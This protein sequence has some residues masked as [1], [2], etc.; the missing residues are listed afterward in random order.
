MPIH[1]ISSDLHKGNINRYVV[2]LA[3]TMS[4]FRSLGLSL[5]DVIKAVTVAPANAL[6][7]RQ[8]G[9][10]TLEPG[11]PANISIF[12]ETEQPVEMEDAEGIVRVSSKWIQPRWCLINGTC[13]ETCEEI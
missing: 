5:E 1:T 7:L 2:S 13:F 3:R 10:G 11:K 6:N 4:K 9:F 12:E 8:Y